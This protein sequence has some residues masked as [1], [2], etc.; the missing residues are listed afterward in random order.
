MIAGGAWTGARSRAVRRLAPGSSSAPVV[1]AAC[2]ALAGSLACGNNPYPEE[3]AE[4]KIFYTTFVEA[5]R[6]LDPA[7]A[8]TTSA[9]AVTGNVYD[10][11]LEYH[12]LKRPYTLIPGI[13]EAVPEPEALPDGRIRYH[14]HLRP[15]LRFHDDPAFAAMGSETPRAITAQDIAFQL[16]RIADPAVNSPVVTPF[17]NLDGFGDFAKRLTEARKADEAFA[18]L[19]VHEQYA[20]V[21]APA[22][23][24][25]ESD[26]DIAV[27][28]SRPYPQIL[29]WFAM[30]FTT[31]MA[32]E[33]VA[34]YDGRE[35]RPSL[36]DHPVGSG[37]YRLVDYEKQSR[38]VLEASPAWYGVRHPEWRAPAATYPSEGEPGDRAAGLLDADVVGRPLPFIERIEFRREKESIPAFSKFLQG[39][40]DAS[41]I[42]RES[43]DKVIREDGLS[44]EMRDLGIRLEKSVIP[45]VY[46]I[47]FNMDDPVVGRAGGERSRKLRQAMSLVIDTEEYTRLFLNGRGIAAQSPLPPGLFGYDADYHNPYRPREGRVDWDRA[48][49]LLAEAG[50]EGGIDPATSRPL[51][52][53]FD[54]PDT[55]A[56]GRL[57]FQFYVDAW[58]KLGLDVRI[59]AT[60][61]NQFQEKVRNGAYQIF[62]WGWVADYPD[63]ENFY[64]LLTSDMARSKSGGPNTANFADEYFDAVFAEMAVRPNDERRL[65]LVRELRTILER[66]RPWIELM[67]PEDYALFHGWL[68]NVKPAGMSYPTTKY[69]DLDADERAR[70]RTAWNEP[71]VWPAWA[72]VALFV[73]GAVPGVVTFYRERQ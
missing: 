55:S 59:E 40:Y 26:R 1:L 57:R 56:Q 33:A 14:F 60:N 8:Y 31:P 15:E 27:I 43:F 64:F 47:G 51:T 71:I 61:Y 13:A 16:M 73:V 3:D 32:W 7:V 68:H 36:A 18:A 70:L 29:F 6:T 2:A 34:W 49:A 66:E 54:T 41:G 50:Y 17:S 9:H 28:L 11:L 69:R 25:V 44:P 37:P 21:G 63:P 46:Y 42:I 52:M 19:P 23:I 20:A 30:E 10:T 35:G 65:E 72:L 62:S 67:H 38:M 53:N 5:P 22:G 12:Y 58:R 39:Y 45:A 48:R 4:R 24:A